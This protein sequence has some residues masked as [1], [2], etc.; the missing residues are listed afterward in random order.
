MNYSEKIQKIVNYIKSGEKDKK[1]F[2]IG[3]ESE[4]FVI[5]KNTGESISFYNEGGIEESMNEIAQKGFEK[6]LENGRLIGLHK[7]GLSISV[8]P[9]SQFELALD[10]KSSIHDLYQAYKEQ[11]SEVIEVFNKKDQLLAMVGYQPKTKI[12]DIKIIPKDRYKYMYQYFKT[13]GGAYAHNMMK[14][15]ASLQCAIDYSN[16]DDFRKKYF[17]ANALGPFIYTIFDNSYIFEG[18]VYKKR[19][20]RQMIWD[21]CDRSRTGVYPFS[22]DKDLSYEKYAAKIL[23]TDII[24]ISENGED[25]Y[26]ADTKFSQI[27]DK[28][29]SDEMIFHALSIV[30]PDVRAKKY[31]EIRMADEIPYPYNFALVALIKGLFYDEDN[32]ND[33]YDLFSDMDMASLTNLKSRCERFGLDASYKDTTIANYAIRFIEMARCSLKDEAIYLDGLENLIR[34]GK[35]PRDVYESLYKRDP[36]KAYSEFSVNNSLGKM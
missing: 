13:Y 3:F 36:K 16:E 10:A 15:S 20:L 32:L 9:A 25:I 26:K 23:D 1:D 22:F 34:E 29:S 12:D 17:V 21:N 33:L 19:N 30:F 24:F 5:D 8:E 14:G 35:T 11:M 2:K 7:D 27:M 28:D 4:H 6:H 18:E 31:I